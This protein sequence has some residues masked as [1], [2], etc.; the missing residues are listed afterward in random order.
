[1]TASLKKV[2][3]F[4]P[5]ELC[6]GITETIVVLPTGTRGRYWMATVVY[7]SVQRRVDVFDVALVVRQ[8]GGALVAE[9]LAA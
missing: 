3:C 5:T 7:D 8:E 9:Q 6:K 1:M 2:V 4:K